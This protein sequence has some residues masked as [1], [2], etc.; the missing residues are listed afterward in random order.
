MK[1]ALNNK[2]IRVFLMCV[3]VVTMLLLCMVG[4]AQT[5]EPGL[6]FTLSVDPSTLTA[7]GEVTVSARVDNAGG[8]D[9][10]LPLSLYD[11]DGKLVTSFG[12]GGILYRL[13]SGESFPWQGKYTVKQSQLDD[14][15]LVYTLRYSEL[16]A[17]GALIEQNL[18]ATAEI[19][20][21]G[22][23]V[24]LQVTRTISPEVVRRGKEATVVYE[25]VNRG[26]TKLVNIQVKENRLVSARTQTVALLDPG[27]STKVTFTKPNVTGDLTSSAL[28]TYR[29]DG[30]RRTQQATIAPV[31]IPLASPGLVYNLTADKTQVNIGE[32][33]LLTLEIKNTGNISYSN[34][35]VSDPRL[36]E[37]FT[38]VQIPAGQTKKLQK[39]VT[40]N[41][42]ATYD[43]TLKLEDN[44][45]TSQEEKVP[46]LRVSAY[47]EGQMLRLNLTLTAGSE[48]ISSLPGDVSF[49]LTVTNDS[50]TAAKN[51]RISHGALDILTIPDLAPGQ[52]TQVERD[53]RLSQAGKYQFTATAT[54]VQN[55]TVSFTS[56]LMSIAYIPP[57]PAP[58]REI[59]ATMAPLVTL[60]PVPADFTAPGGQVR[61]ALFIVTLA[62]A[63]LFGLALILFL[64]SSF[65]RARARAK[66]NAAYDTFQISGTRDYT[67]P[68][69][70]DKQ[71]LETEDFETAL[72][73]PL[74]VTKRDLE[75]PHEKYLNQPSVKAET[76]DKTKSEGAVPKTQIAEDEGGYRLVRKDSPSKPEPKKPEQR[77]R[78][79]SRRKTGDNEGL[80]S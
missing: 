2:R 15:K 51:I 13:N 4:S 60:S 63:A 79:S 32:T 22:E 48:T 54:D 37:V 25:L 27:A 62:F 75:M 24:D 33:V 70:E 12:D 38:N 10:T 53:F 61:N 7:P 20:Y 68:P 57:T 64:I 59:I 26:N 41:E 17:G 6:T 45:G 76:T 1:Y 39:E 52:S 28:I 80:D 77:A 65:A 46:A 5:T 19:T 3:W 49:Y 14:G 69:S 43:F 67:A 55:N 21:T 23:E 72:E 30:E 47:S 50:N 16:A 8:E 29:K 74:P 11:P 44:T 73:D 18:P 35:A 42:T 71:A 36:G 34:V 58:T 40:V 56:N 9:I 31:Q 78:R 66:S